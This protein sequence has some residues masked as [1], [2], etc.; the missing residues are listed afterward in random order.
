[1]D[2]YWVSYP[3]KCTCAT[4]EYT[5]DNRHSAIGRGAALSVVPSEPHSS[6]SDLN[7]RARCAALI[8]RVY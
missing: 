2:I 7:M 5:V 3:F 1:M 4:L 6:V 8:C